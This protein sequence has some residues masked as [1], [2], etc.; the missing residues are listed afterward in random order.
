MRSRRCHLVFAPLLVALTSVW[1]CSA[2]EDPPSNQPNPPKVDAAPDRAPPLADPVPD[3]GSD[4]GS[5]PQEDAPKGDDPPVTRP[6]GGVDGGGVAPTDGGGAVT[7]AYVRND[8]GP[9]GVSARA[10]RQTCVPPVDYKHPVPTLSATGCVDASDPKKPAASLIPYDVISP[11]YSDGADKQRFMAIPDG[12]VVHVKDCTKEPATCKPKT[13]GGNAW[14]E[15]HFEF[16]VNTVLVK[17]FLFAG[18][19]VET[20]LFVRFADRW[21]GFSYQWNDAQT[22]AAIVGIDGDSQPIMNAANKTQTWNFPSRGACMDCHNEASGASL[23]PETM[24]FDRMFDYPS[25]IKANQIATLEHLGVFD[26]PVAKLKPLIDYRDTAATTEARA[27]SY[28]H[29]NCATCH[30]PDGP[31]SGIDM[32]IT[33]SNAQM[34]LCN[35]APQKGDQGVAGSKLIVPATPA[36]SLVSLRMQAPA[37]PTTGRMPQIGTNVLDAAGIK[38]VNDWITA[39]KTCP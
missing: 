27:R 21:T 29:A 22:D 32:R 14:N 31:F 25:G 34:N 28:L 1:G 18:K 11:L 15:G 30:R 17:S 6:E 2:A 8:G 5:K 10:V 7:D 24:Q 9:F 12:A 20:R 3:A 19:F 33:A 38:I 39:T 4:R 36:K 26:A 35:V 23:G 13:E 37:G 16:P